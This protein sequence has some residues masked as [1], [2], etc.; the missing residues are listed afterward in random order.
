MGLLKVHVGLVG[1]EVVDIH[2]LLTLVFAL[3]V[4]VAVSLY[5]LQ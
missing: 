4:E 2:H 1:F 5:Q 3:K